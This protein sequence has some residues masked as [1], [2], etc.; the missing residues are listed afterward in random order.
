[1]TDTAANQARFDEIKAHAGVDYRHA[2]ALAREAQLIVRLPDGSTGVLV[3]VDWLG[4]P[5]IEINGRSSTTTRFRFAEIKAT[6]YAAE[7]TR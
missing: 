5:E 7:V 3:T 4:N 6:G 2:A 1:M